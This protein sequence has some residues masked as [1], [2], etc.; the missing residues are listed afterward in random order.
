MKPNIEDMK[1]S[2]QDGYHFWKALMEQAGIEFV[3]TCVKRTEKEQFALWA[4][5]RK[6]L[7]EVN[8]LRRVAGMPPISKSEN[9]YKVTWTLKSK[10]FV[11]PE[12][13][14]CSAFDFALVLPNKKVITWDTKWDKDHDGVPE[15]LEAAALAKKAGLISGAYWNKPDF[16][17]IQ[18]PGF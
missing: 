16:P 3:L 15:Y 12:D 1:P 2:L 14:L 9:A 5:N 4:Q 18:L 10:H 6:P 11:D 7:L 8:N 13:G 17:H